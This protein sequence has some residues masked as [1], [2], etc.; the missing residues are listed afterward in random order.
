MTF[1]SVPHCQLKP[2]TEKQS[3]GSLFC[4]IPVQ[5]YGFLMEP[6]KKT[7][8]IWHKGKETLLLFENIQI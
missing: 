7:G 3:A 2:Q 5:K 6:A 1:S 4:L 8:K